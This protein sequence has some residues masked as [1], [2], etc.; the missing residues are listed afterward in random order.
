MRREYIRAQLSLIYHKVRLSRDGQWHVQANPGTAWMLFALSD[1]EAE[2][3]LEPPGK[4]VQACGC[5]FKHSDAAGV[6]EACMLGR[7]QGQDEYWTGF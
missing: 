5:R 1:G 6:I 3:Q 4:G 7:E 2:E